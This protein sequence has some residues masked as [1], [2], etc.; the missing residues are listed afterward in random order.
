MNIEIPEELLLPTLEE[1]EKRTTEDLSS[2][3]KPCKR[4]GKKERHE[5][6]RKHNSEKLKAIANEFDKPKHTSQNSL[7]TLFKQDERPKFN[8]ATVNIPVPANNSSSRPILRATLEKTSQHGVV[9][10]SLPPKPTISN[11][12]KRGRP[13]KVN[14]L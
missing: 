12:R 8:L 13:P 1:L 10:N 2:K 9:T 4:P 11:I 14:P 7:S 6:K 3:W 5:I